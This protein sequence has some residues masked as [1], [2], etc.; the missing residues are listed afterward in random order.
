MDF[1]RLHRN[2][3]HGSTNNSV[4][5]LFLSFDLSRSDQSL[6]YHKSDTMQK[7]IT[8]TSWYV[9]IPLSVSCG[10]TLISQQTRSDFSKRINTRL[11]TY[12]IF[13]SEISY[14]NNSSLKMQLPQGVHY[15][16]KRWYT[17]MYVKAVW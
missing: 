4:R 9:F 5:S 17:C 11:R 13:N 6:V 16:Q 10:S 15:H 7:Y 8:N 1:F 2:P 12:Y 14:V 3:F